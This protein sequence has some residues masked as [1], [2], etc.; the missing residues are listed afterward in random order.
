MKYLLILFLAVSSRAS[1]IVLPPAI[2]STANNITIP[3]T[4][5]NTN[6]W[7]GLYVSP[8]LNSTN[9]TLFTTLPAG[10]FHSSDSNQFV[11]PFNNYTVVSS[12]LVH[13]GGGLYVLVYTTN[14]YTGFRGTFYTTQTNLYQNAG[15]FTNIFVSGGSISFGGVSG[16]TL[17]TN[18]VYYPTAF[19]NITTNFNCFFKLYQPIPVTPPGP[20]PELNSADIGTAIKTVISNPNYSTNFYQG[21]GFGFTVCL[22]SFAIGFIRSVSHDHNEEI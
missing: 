20:P 2:N 22:S 15:W 6:Y 16:G 11:Y 17:T 7:L 1:L 19:W 18:I 14:W 8:V 21:L 4:G 12:R 5:A 9:W 3:F 13:M 10:T